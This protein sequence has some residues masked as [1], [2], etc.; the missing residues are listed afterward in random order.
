MTDRWLAL[1]V[2]AACSHARPE[3]APPPRPATSCGAAA[4]GLV[5]LVVANQSEK[6]PEDAVDKLRVLITTRCREDRWS[7]E[8][9]GCLASV[10]TPDDANTCGTLLT[11]DQQAALVKAQEKPPP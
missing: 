2:L 11:E 1:V 4:D 7:T 6:P 8:A 9:Q 10:K 3:P 5:G